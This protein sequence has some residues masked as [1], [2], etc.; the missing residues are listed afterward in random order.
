M[1]DVSRLADQSFISLVYDYQKILYLAEGLFS[2]DFPY[3]FGVTLLSQECSESP[4]CKKEKKN[5]NE[6]D[7]VA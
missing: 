3:S 4:F 1:F 5:R 7:L 6:D 2:L